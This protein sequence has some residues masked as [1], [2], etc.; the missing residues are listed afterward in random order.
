M[1][2]ELVCIGVSGT[3]HVEG[4]KASEMVVGAG[5]FKTCTAL[6]TGCLDDLKLAIEHMY[7]HG[8]VEDVRVGLVVSGELCNQAPVA[9]LPCQFH[10]LVEG[11]HLSQD[12]ID[13]PHGERHDG[14]V[15]IV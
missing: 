11:R 2:S 4:L 10:G 14:G 13:E 12:G 1:K 7:L 3:A 15:V 6:T 8:D 5:S 9:G